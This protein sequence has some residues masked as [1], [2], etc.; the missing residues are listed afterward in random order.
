M[1][2][3]LAATAALVA[4]AGIAAA[5]QDP[6]APGG[7]GPPPLSN[8]RGDSGLALLMRRLGSTATIMMATAHPDDE[9]NGL[10][11]MLSYGQGARTILAS[12]TRGDGG[13]N[14]IGPELFDAL[15]V[16]RTEE[17]LAA[18][19]YDG[20]EQMFTR[21]VDFG[22]SF[23]IEETFEKWGRNEIVGDFARLMRLTRPDVVIALRPDGPGGGQHHQASAILAREAFRAAGDPTRYP[24]QLTGGVHPWQPKKFYFTARFGFPGEEPAA[25]TESLLVTDTATYDPVVGW[26]YADIG[27]RARSMHKCQGMAQLLSL[28]GQAFFRNVRYRLVDSAIS[29]QI[30]N[31]ESSFFDGIDTSIPGLA[32]FLGDR[33]GAAA[34][35]LA[36]VARHVDAARSKFESGGS[37][38]ALPDLLAGLRAVRSLRQH[39]AQTPVDAGARTEVDGRLLRKEHEFQQAVLLANGVRIE[40][41]TD[42]GVVT[43]GQDVRLNLVVAGYGP[44]P[45]QVRRVSFDGFEGDAPC[46]AGVVKSGIVYSC[47]TMA[48]VPIDARVTTPYWKRLTDA[49]RYTFDPATPFGMPFTPTPFRARIELAFETGSNG[50]DPLSPVHVEMPLAY[51]Y[52]G[53]IFSGE[54]RME[55]HVVPAWSLRAAPDIAIVPSG[56][57]GAQDAPSAREIRV[58]VV[59]GSRG[60]ASASVRLAAPDGWRVAPGAEDVTLTRQDEARTLRFTVTPPPNTPPGEYRL[61]ATATAANAEFSTGYQ[62]VEYPHIQR[63]HLVLPAET[64]LKVIDVKIAPGLEVGYVMGVGDQVPPA[65]AQLG[66]SVEFLDADALAWGDLS[67]YDVIVTGVRAYERRADLRANNDRLLQYAARGGTVVVQY[68]KFEFNEAQY[69]PYPAKVSSNRISEESAPVR[70]L[71]PDHPVF[72]TPNPIG[73]GVWSSWVQER[74]LYFLGDRDPRY[75]DL[76]EMEDPFPFN[77]GVKRG[78]L[79]EGRVG[80][81]RWIYVGLG[82]WRQLPAGADGAYQLLANLLSLGARRAK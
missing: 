61:R 39:L 10:L 44:M 76:V 32:A 31:P 5:R 24:E 36:A 13:Q 58:T 69:G 25:S 64:T 30:R 81:G 14:E 46:A 7:G 42:D 82:L 35:G 9:N 6:L 51:R 68:N 18:H 63:R 40:A 45:M 2:I 29:G 41:L 34:P 67:R 20:A 73:P 4:A 33:A 48:R 50:A 60:T 3:R 65:I 55:L 59:N 77:R 16:L 49:E 43:A 54:K 80:D 62:V 17:L 57:Q 26:T 38:A 19:R 66:A 11:A 71:V 22:Y 47:S 27:T 21:A 74:G 79:V 52:E 56:A 75:A 53:N 23:S 8:E 72:T 12:A 37:A 28:P 78:A 1:L 15:A 70:V